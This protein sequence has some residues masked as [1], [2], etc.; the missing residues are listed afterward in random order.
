MLRFKEV[1]LLNFGLDLAV[2][3]E[4]ACIQVPENLVSLGTKQGTTGFGILRGS[5]R[6]E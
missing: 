5:G 4:K 1:R 2:C 3:R 6:S